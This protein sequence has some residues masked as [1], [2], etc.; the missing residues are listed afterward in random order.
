MRSGAGMDPQRDGARRAEH[1]EG[2][3]LDEHPVD[4]GVLLLQPDRAVA[5]DDRDGR[6]TEGP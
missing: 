3:E 4:G 6:S 1:L 2:L 5:V